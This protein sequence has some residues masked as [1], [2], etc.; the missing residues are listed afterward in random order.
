MTQQWDS[1]RYACEV[2]FVATLGEPLLA[3]LAPVPHE[4]ILDV[5]C[6]DGALTEKLLPFGCQITA[7]DS[8]SHQIAAAIRRGLDAHVIDAHALPYAEEFDAVLSNAALHWMKD[9]DKVLAGVARA[10]VPDGRFVAEM[11]GAG[12]VAR[13][14]NSIGGLLNREGIELASVNPWY[15]PTPNEYRERLSAHGFDIVSMEHFERPTK[16]DGDITAWLEIFATS[17]FAAFNPL[18]RTKLLA[19]LREELRSDLCDAKGRWT[20]D[21][22]RLRFSAV[23]RDKRS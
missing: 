6:G 8:S 11:G 15:F 4:R 21:Y 12:N 10:L 23:K 3:L 1:N 13:I 16:L 22:V 5:G 18:H 2:G 20:V 17:F 7:V 19:R 9:P 14:V